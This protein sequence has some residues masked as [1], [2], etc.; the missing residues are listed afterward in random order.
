MALVSSIF[1]VVA[2]GSKWSSSLESTRPPDESSRFILVGARRVFASSK[3]TCYLHGCHHCFSQRSHP[4]RLAPDGLMVE[5]VSEA[6]SGGNCGCFPL[7]GFWRDGIVFVAKMYQRE[8]EMALDDARRGFAMR[9]IFHLFL[10]TSLFSLNV[11]GLF[12]VG[13]NNIC[14]FVIAVGLTT[15]CCM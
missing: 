4:G 2:M 11:S 6:F 1:L 10:L 5:A 13:N 7:D 15:L 8:E 9:L 3:N 14:I 12:P